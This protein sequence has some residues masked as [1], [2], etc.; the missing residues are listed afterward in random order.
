M[1]DL[2]KIKRRKFFRRQRR[3]R[4]KMK[5]SGIKPRLSVFR[6]LT[7][8]SVQAID[9]INRKTLVATSSK[10]IKKKGQG[11]EIANLVGELMGKKLGEKNIKEAIFDKGAYK[12]HG[13][14]KA[15][16]DGIRK[17]KIKF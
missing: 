10:E 16:A 15:L 8:I 2:N 14:V 6:S 1:K 3:A 7:S 12:Y 5:G 4:A 9:D 13:R 11:M 17:N